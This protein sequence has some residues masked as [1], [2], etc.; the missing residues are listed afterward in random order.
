MKIKQKTIK[1]TSKKQTFEIFKTKQKQKKN[2][3]FPFEDFAVY[4]AVT[5]R[6]VVYYRGNPKTK[7]LILS[8][9]SQWHR[10]YFIHLR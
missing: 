10:Y 8:N 9:E 6:F 4:F 2:N 1:Q 5:C 7:H 3:K